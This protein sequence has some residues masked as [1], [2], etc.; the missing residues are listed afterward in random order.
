MS[1][2]KLIPTVITAGALM[3]PAVAVGDDTRA[4]D[5]AAAMFPANPCNGRLI[6]QEATLP[7]GTLGETTLDGTCVLRLDPTQLAAYPACARTVTIVHEAG[8]QALH[9]AGI[10]HGEHHHPDPANV[11]HGR[12]ALDSP[13]CKPA[14]PTQPSTRGPAFTTRSKAV[15]RAPWHLRARFR[16]RPLK[17]IYR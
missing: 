7:A 6:I 4:F 12:V 16:M 2:H 15:T 9:A 8:H 1:R 11:M 17:G 14:E 5:L 3:A 10:P 13:P